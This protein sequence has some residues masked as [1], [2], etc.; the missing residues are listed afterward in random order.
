MNALITAA[1]GVTD[2]GDIRD[3]EQIMEDFPL[4]N[5]PHRHRGMLMAAAETAWI[6]KCE[7]AADADMRA[8]MGEC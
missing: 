8:Q 1:T 3:I 7:W 5:Q 6:M 2:P 4:R